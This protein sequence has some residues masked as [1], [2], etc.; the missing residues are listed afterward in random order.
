MIDIDCSNFTS[1]VLVLLFL[2]FLEKIKS[3]GMFLS[4]I[5]ASVGN[6]NKKSSKFW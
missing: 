4:E 6:A 5:F 2:V 1:N 3:F